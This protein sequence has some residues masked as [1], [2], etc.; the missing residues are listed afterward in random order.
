M[1][2]TPY[3]S[4]LLF[5]SA[6]SLGGC[7]S[8]YHEVSTMYRQG[9]GVMKHDQKKAT[10]YLTDLQREG[11]TDGGLLHIIGRKYREGDGCG[12][13]AMKARDY[14][15]L[16]ID[17]EY[18]P[19]YLSM[20]MMYWGGGYRIP[21]DTTKAIHTLLE[22]EK[23]G[24]KDDRILSQLI[25]YLRL[26]PN[27]NEELLGEFSDIDEMALYYSD[28]LIQRG[29]PKGYYYK[30]L[31]TWIGDDYRRTPA[32]PHSFLGP[33]KNAMNT[34]LT[35]FSRD[36]DRAIST[37]EEADRLGLAI[38]SVYTLNET[39]LC[40]VYRYVIPLY[41]FIINIFISVLRMFAMCLS[42]STLHLTKSH[43]AIA[44]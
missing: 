17:K 10:V 22:A 9:C 28:I 14:Y 21:R 12:I 23:K 43:I 38:L 37:W 40:D 31:I 36:R 33:Y 16:A 6:T 15:Q 1:P 41:I 30:G 39:N 11:Y 8:S 35:Y 3:L 29:S 5:V 18:I 19:G 42:H 27:P 24:I 2:A 20:S 26:L 13:S 4:S 7:S 32:D 44:S 34:I 25:E